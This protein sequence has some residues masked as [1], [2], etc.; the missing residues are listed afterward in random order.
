MWIP[1]CTPSHVCPSHF[2]LFYCIHIADERGKRMK[3]R[4]VLCGTA[5]VVS[6]LLLFQL[7]SLRPVSPSLPGTDAAPG[8]LL[9]IWISSS[10][11]GSE[12]WLRSCL[13][14]WEKKH[15]GIMTFVRTVSPEEIT[16]EDVVLPDIMLYTP[17]DFTAPQQIFVPLT[18]LDG[19]RV[20]AL[21]AGAWQGK[22][23]GLPLCYAG[24]VLAI[25]SA[26]EPHSAAAPSPTTL[27][28]RPAPT[29]QAPPFPTPELPTNI[30]LCI[31]KGVGL[32][33]LDLLHVVPSFVHEPI[34]LTSSQVFSRFRSRQASAALLT[35]GQVTALNGVFPFRVMTPEEI[36]TDQLW[37]SSLFPHAHD[38]AADLLA[39]LTSMEAQRKLTGQC[40][41]SVR[42]DLRLYASGTEG[43]MESAAAH[44]LTFINAYVPASD[45]E[46]A[47]WQLFQGRITRHEALL[48][49]L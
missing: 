24:Y 1:G 12:S 40:L 47:A 43:L 38:P 14:S 6:I 19:L 39:Y 15:P 37:L 21:R 48:P 29:E 20:E 46:Q 42:E 27:L 18:N 49:L 17:G 33:T 5:V 30:S 7:S 28:G 3:H 45:A 25:D 41:Y 23:Y 10:I 35:T 26:A 22:Q 32:F 16:R 4:W 9:R 31:P 44:G 36:I 8:Q 13:K 34:E 11:G 2:M